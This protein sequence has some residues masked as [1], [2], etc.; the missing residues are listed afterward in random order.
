MPSQPNRSRS[1]AAFERALQV[2]PGGVNSPA[3]AFGGVGGQPLFIARG[4]GPHLFDIDGNKYL[5]YI[6]SWGPLILGHCH[7]QVVE[8]AIAAVRGGSSYGAPCERE[9]QLAEMIREAMPSVEM[10]RMV[11]SGTE[12]SMSAI[13]LALT[14][15]KIRDCFSSEG[16]GSSMNPEVLFEVF[17]QQSLPN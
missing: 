11:S 9:T 15:D 6:A 4:E 5:D 10:V 2:I 13:R 14:L 7:P 1:R 16:C 12:A 8:A 3:R 17:S